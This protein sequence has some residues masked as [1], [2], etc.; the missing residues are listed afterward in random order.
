MKKFTNFLIAVLALF[1]AQI[2]IYAQTTGTVSGTVTDPT[3]AVVSGANV[4]LKN[5]ATGEERSTSANDKGSFTFATVQPGIYTV[6]VEGKGFKKS[7]AADVSVQVSKE[8]S[9]AIALEIGGANEVVTVTDTQEV[10]NSSTPSLTNVINTKQVENLPL[11]A[12]NPLDLAA[13]QAG[14]AVTGTG[15]RTSSIGGLRGSATNVT[16]DGINAMDNFVKTDSLFALTAPSLGSTSEFSITT[17]TTDSTAGRG[18]GQVNVVTRGGTNEYHGSIFYLMRNSALNANNFFNNAS[19]TPR[20]DLHQ[21]YYGFTI[22]GPVYFL[23]FG[24][25][26]KRIWDGHNKAFFFFSYEGFREKF[27]A[28]R[29]RTVMTA[30][31]RKGLFTYNGTD[32]VQ[33]TVDLLALA[34]VPFKTLNPITLAQINAMP[35]PNNTLV[36]DG[37]NTAGARF[38]VVGSDPSDK[39][40]TRYDHQ[41]VEKSKFGAHK[42]EFV[43]N[44]AHFSLFPDTFNAIEAPFPGGIDAGQDSVRSLVTGALVSTFGQAVN[45]FRYGRQWSPVG[46]IRNAPPTG[47]FITLASPTT[48]YDNSFMSQGRNTSVNQYT[49]TFA[50]PKGNHFLQFGVDYQRIYAYTFNDAGINQTITLGGNSANPTGLL[51]A[52]FPSISTADFNRAGPI[53]ADLVGLLGSVSQTYN[54]TSATSGFVAG[55]TRE[56]IFQQQ[57]VAIYGQDQWKAKR[58]LTLNYGVRWEFEGVPTIPNGLAIQPDPDTIFGISGK[59]NLFNPT[60]PAG[61]PAAVA[62]LRFVSGDTGIPLYND[63]WNNFA[64]F[65]GLAYSPAFES[66]FLRTLFGSEGKSS[67]RLGYSVSYLHDGFTV[68]S[69]AMGTGT[70]NPGLI[71]S[72]ANTTPTGVLTGAI[73]LPA[74]VFTSTITDKGN[75]D[76]NPNNGLWGIDKN[77]RIPY[78]QQWNIGYE[79]EIAR[80][81]AIEVRYVGNHAVK[82]WRAVDF[83]EVNIFENGFLNEFKN[84]QI[85]LNA[86]GGSNFAPGCAGCVATPILDKFFTGLASTSTSGYGST[87]FISNLIN[88]NIGTMANTLAFSNTYKANRQSAAVGLPANFFVANPNAL[89]ARLLTNDSMSNYHALQAEIRQR[90]T[91]GLQFQANYTFSKSLTDAFGAAGS[92]SDLANFRTLRNKHLDYMRSSQDQTHRFVANAVYDLP[93]G[94]GQ[95]LF[96]GVNSVVNQ[97]IGN[98]TVGAIVTW[99]GRPPFYIASGRTTYNNSGGIN[100]AKLV[101]MS[102]EQFAGNVGLYRTSSGVFYINPAILDCTVAGSSA[103]VT[104]TDAV[105]TITASRLKTGIMTA[106]DPGTFG[107][108]PINSI[109]GPNYF[110]VDMSLVKRF[111]VG[112]RVKLELK[113]TFINILNNPNWAFGTQNFDSTSFGRITGTS[114]NDRIIHFQGTMNF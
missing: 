65:V 85:N 47:P 54:V 102:F 34:N 95:S 52:N 30:N 86:R 56:R 75:F 35:L 73:T 96:N 68:I 105:G 100:P 110:N 99:Q 74:P 64:P 71:Q 17:G 79:R 40:V 60:A 51:A 89:F 61:P 97:I 2:A 63:D 83:N 112:E 22:G 13:L 111:K 38:N 1:F 88:N 90:L 69:N 21:H 114:G 78:V 33:R 28:T 57:D 6:T 113:T 107:N 48:N 32:G 58:N 94:R 76:L 70:T 4:T 101:G 29:N 36:G 12:R 5:N 20:P 84:A 103:T 44:R 82:V 77:L 91:R 62:T 11:A 42:L 66:G 9:L 26:G 87:T 106:P 15:T 49:D 67:F 24:E 37:L 10:I 53:Y 80:N 93:I 81:M 23:Q 3:G 16:Q 104:C 72:A 7:L 50:M 98:W 92:Q 46:F 108:F 19:G 43:Y 55:A 8:T 18:V 45:T 27:Q 14:I 39:Y 31:A 41:L 25:G 109:N 59:N